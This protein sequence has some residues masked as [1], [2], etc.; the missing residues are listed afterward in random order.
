[1]FNRPPSQRKQTERV[2]E[3][4]VGEQ[5]SRDGRPA[6]KIFTRLKIGK[7]LDLKTADRARH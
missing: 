5:D 3:V 2:V 7:G 4:G 1:M 6:K